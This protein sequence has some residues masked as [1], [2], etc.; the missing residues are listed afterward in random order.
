MSIVNKFNTDKWKVT[1]SNFPI[2]ETRTTKLDLS[3]FNNYVKTI[4]LPDFS[5]E[6]LPDNFG[7]YSINHSVSKFNNNLNAL[8]IEFAVDEDMENYMAFYEWYREL[9]E[10]RPT[11]NSKTLHQSCISDILVQFLDNQGRSGVILKFSECMLS[12]SSSLNLIYGSSDYVPFS[13]TFVYN[14]IQ[15][16]KST[17]IKNN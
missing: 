17:T 13:V 8:T 5:I 6:A 1:F 2:P 11:K 3:V 7:G 10:G 15:L 14:K 9:R 12:N 16:I 4:S